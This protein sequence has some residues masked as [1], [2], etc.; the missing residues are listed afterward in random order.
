MTI[1]MNDVLNQIEDLRASL[2]GADR[3]PVRTLRLPES[4]EAEITSLTEAVADIVTNE[5]E[6]T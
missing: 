5:A 1:A 6:N 4:A 3:D 2:R